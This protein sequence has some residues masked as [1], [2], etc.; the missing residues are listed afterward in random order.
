MQYDAADLSPR[1]RYKVLTSFVLPRP[2][3]WVTS[4]GPSG[5]IN[6][7]PFSFFNVFGANPPICAFAPGDRDNGRGDGRLTGTTP[8]QPPARQP[9]RT[10]A[11]SPLRPIRAESRDVHRVMM[12]YF[13]LLRGHSGVSVGKVTQAFFARPQDEP[14]TTPGPRA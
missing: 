6:A 7:A 1:E 8:R 12:P 5:V 10:A 13:R 9:C 11:P 14:A 2:I 3:A 4:L